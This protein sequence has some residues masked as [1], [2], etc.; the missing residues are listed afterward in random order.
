MTKYYTGNGDSGKTSIMSGAS[1]PK[2][3]VLIDAIGD[4]DELNSAV[5][6][7]LFYVRDDVLRKQLKLIQNELFSI[8]ALLAAVESKEFS[9]AK[10]E[11]K[12][13]ER[14]ENEIN[15][16]GTKMPE[17]TKFV[18]PDGSEES[19]HLHL[20]R[21]VARRAERKVSGAAQ[22]YKINTE[23]L[24][25]LNRLS[26]FLFAAALYI[27]HKNGIEESNPVY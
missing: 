13:I 9:K 19:V 7:A 21:S 6:A 12:Q 8:G 2:D 1:L 3:D 23:V 15:T 25:Y 24:A 26:S 18:L 14:L 4:V 10:I 17:L 20:A 11:R 27:N 16:M 22:K 5:G